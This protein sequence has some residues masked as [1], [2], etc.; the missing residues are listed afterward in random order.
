[1]SQYNTSVTF[2]AVVIS[3]V[4]ISCRTKIRY[5]QNGKWLCFHLLSWA[6]KNVRNF[7]FPAYEIDILWEELD[8]SLKYKYD[9]HII[10]S[11][12][13]LLQHFP[14][15]RDLSQLNQC[16]IWFEFCLSFSSCSFFQS[17][18]AQ[19]CAITVNSCTNREDSGPWVLSPPW[20]LCE[21][22]VKVLSGETES[23]VT[24]ARFKYLSTMSQ[25]PK[26]K[27]NFL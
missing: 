15:K 5:R 19:R 22:P 25:S 3:M 16:T 12:S 21:E 11:R 7:Q 1:M 2:S 14:W 8:L 9:F 13:L 20:L 4:H 6:E 10:K 27:Q 24:T 26:S 18:K 17:T 23:W